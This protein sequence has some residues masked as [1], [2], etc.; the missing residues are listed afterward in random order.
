MIEGAEAA[1]EEVK[2]AFHK[3]EI[4]CVV[5][6]SSLVEPKVHI[7]QGA[8]EV[9]NADMRDLR[10]VWESTSFEIDRLQANPEHV[11]QEQSGLSSRSAPPFQLTYTAK[12][13]APAILA[14]EDKIPVAIVREEGSNGD[15]EM[16]SAF[17]A[18]GFEP[19]DVT[20]SDLLQAR[21]TLE[22]FKGVVFVGGFSYADVLD[23]A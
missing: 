11:S 13:T 5:I 19:W 2:V 22:R 10:D 8:N 7:H 17:Y 3:A 9:L 14:A 16:A 6:G 21:V 20:M 23:S 15:R 4:P 18:A 1:A 12:P